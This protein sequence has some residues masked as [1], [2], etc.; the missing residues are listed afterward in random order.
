VSDASWW[1][2]PSLVA[3]GLLHGLNP[4]MGWLFAVARGLQDGRAG[5]VLHA[6]FF[7]AA[8]HGTAVAAVAVLTAALGQTVPR[9]TLLV[10][11]GTALLASGAWRLLRRARHPRTRFRA[12]GWEMAW[13]SFLVATAHGAGLMVV[14]LLVSLQTPQP[15]GHHLHGVASGGLHLALLAT[16]VHTAAQLVAMGA[17]A[18][19]VYRFVGLEVLNR[20]WINDELVWPAALALTGAVALAAGA[21]P[22]GL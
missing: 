11:S 7:I 1:A 17:A 18:A 4:G 2:W 6:M 14:P 21:V 12:S 8:G 19:A 20:A 13:W 3:L 9:P 5:A 10:L 16:L 15:S 22:G